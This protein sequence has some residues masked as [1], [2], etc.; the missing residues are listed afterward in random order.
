MVDNNGYMHAVDWEVPSLSE[1][2]VYELRVKSSGR[3]SSNGEKY[4]NIVWR[5]SMGRQENKTAVTTREECRGGLIEE[6]RRKRT[7]RRMEGSRR[8]R[9]RVTWSWQRKGLLPNRGRS[10]DTD[11]RMAAD[12]RRRRTVHRGGE[13]VEIRGG[14]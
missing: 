13:P 7:V 3:R 1:A 14:K 9:E 11:R 12:T 8:P 5:M 4:T 2:Y 10:W 6:L